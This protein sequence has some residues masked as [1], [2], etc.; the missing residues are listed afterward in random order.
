MAVTEIDLKMFAAKIQARI[1]QQLIG[2]F[3]GLM[4]SLLVVAILPVKAD[5]KILQILDR[6]VTAMLP[7]VGGAV[8]F[9]MAR[10]RQTSH[11]PTDFPS[12]PVIPA[13]TPETSK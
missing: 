2:A 11:P 6:I 7:I 10:E 1:T 3:V 4:F 12:Q 9:W 13:P 8:G 5:D